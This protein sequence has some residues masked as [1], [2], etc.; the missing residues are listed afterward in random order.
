MT[1]NTGKKHKRNLQAS[2]TEFYTKKPEEYNSGI[3]VQYTFQNLNV[4]LG[5]I[6]I[7]M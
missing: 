7:F 2:L 5:G 1:K 6:R 3:I 4:T